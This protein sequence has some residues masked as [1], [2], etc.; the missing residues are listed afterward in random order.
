MTKRS[1]D[2]YCGLAVA[3][4][5]LGERWTML[6]VRELLMGPKRFTDLLT[7]LPGIGTG[8][9]TQ[10]LREL[11]EAAVIEKAVLPPPAASTVY[12]LAA[13]G[14]AL[15]P[16][17]LGLT[18]WGLR[19]LGTPAEGQAVNTNLLAFAMAARFNPQSSPAADGDYEL[20]VDGNAFH[21]A[22]T[23]GDINIQ[24]GTA[25]QPRA[26]ISTDIATLVG[27]NNGSSTLVEALTR[28][29]LVVDGD[30]EVIANLA[31]AFEL[32]APTNT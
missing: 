9:L 1:Y 19:R 15:R 24:A 28:Q 18:R 13:D 21:V 27:I 25:H 12:Q 30:P 29:S 16:V 22:I 4:D 32:S 20:R 23:N 10:R 2:E 6:I 17:L 26:T 5:L 31:T 3:L 11:E 8:L 7:G 14:Q